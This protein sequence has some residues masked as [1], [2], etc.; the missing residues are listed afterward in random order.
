VKRIQTI[1]FIG[2]GALAGGLAMLLRNCGYAIGEIISRPTPR[3]QR[4]AAKLAGAVGATSC[5]L[6]EAR[7]DCDLLWLAVPDEA[8]ASVA[9]ELG[10]GAHLPPIVLHASGALSSHALQQLADRG[11]C[12]G[13]AHPLMTFVAGAPPSLAGAWFALEGAPVAVR[14]ARTLATRLGAQSFIIL[15]ESKALYHAFGAML[16]PMLAAELE[17][18]S[19]LGLRAGISAPKLRRL[20]RPIVER[21]VQNVLSQGAAKSFSGP[22]ARGDVRTVAAHLEALDALPEAAVYRALAGYAMQTLPVARGDEMKK[23]LEKPQ[24]KARAGKRIG[25]L[26]ASAM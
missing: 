17:A 7:L 25:K 24:S 5:T 18:A 2:A 13:S 6:A 10:A 1:S 8:I 14:A 4:R 23:L 21:T 9:A 16:S 15:P 22:L 19:R 11:A 12:T 26:S 20:M 3:S